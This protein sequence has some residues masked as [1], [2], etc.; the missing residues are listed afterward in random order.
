[1]NPLSQAGTGS[2]MD[3]PAAAAESGE[4]SHSRSTQDLQPHRQ[5]PRQQ[6]IYPHAN[7]S[8]GL[9]PNVDPHYARMGT[10]RP[11]SYFTP[12]IL[13]EADKTE[14]LLR[15]F[16]ESDPGSDRDTKL[17]ALMQEAGEGCM[18]IPPLF[19]E[20]GSHTR[21]G[22]GVYIGTGVNLQDTGGG[23]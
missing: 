21:L 19:V 13:S 10:G 8:L 12:F 14:P 3:R 9:Q 4:R 5:A 1:M 23:E 6:R 7:P 16:N 18:V 17:K 15:A 20:W 2:A 22:K 11:Y